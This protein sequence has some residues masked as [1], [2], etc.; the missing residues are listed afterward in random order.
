MF[1]DFIPEK[2]IFTI[3]VPGVPLR[4][5]E[6]KNFFFSEPKL[7]VLV[8]AVQLTL[9]FMSGGEQ[10]SFAWC[11]ISLMNMSHVALITNKINGLYF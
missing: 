4:Y 7:V 10:K 1:F 8:K 11:Q 6:K 3:F 2:L 5:H 9:I